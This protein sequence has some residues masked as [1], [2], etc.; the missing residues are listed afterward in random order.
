[1]K[2][3]TPVEFFNILASGIYQLCTEVNEDWTAEKVA[4]RSLLATLNPIEKQEKIQTFLELLKSDT[5]LLKI[6]KE[7]CEF[8]DEHNGAGHVLHESNL[9]ISNTIT[10]AKVYTGKQ[11]MNETDALHFLDLI[12]NA[13][14][15]RSKSGYLELEL[16]RNKE[17]YNED[18]IN[19]LSKP[20]HV[21]HSSIA[22]TLAGNQNEFTLSQQALA[23]R[24][25]IR[26]AL[27]LSD[28]DETDLMRLAH[29]LAAKKLPINE[30]TQRQDV[31]LSPMKSVVVKTRTPLAQKQDLIFVRQFFAPLNRTSSPAVQRIMDKIEKDLDK[32][33]AK[34]KGRK[35]KL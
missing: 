2:N 16:E 24:L 15:T 12:K 6:Q 17:D 10:T 19:R 18:R 23:I 9:L 35:D 25:I 33:E 27:E 13:N 1:M 29:L 11:Q 26:E 28:F 34:E 22:T 8:M 5:S 14:Y 30:K 4:L 20:N 3:L 21:E 31:H 7:I 32:L